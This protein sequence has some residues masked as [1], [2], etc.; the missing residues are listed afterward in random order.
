MKITSKY[1]QYIYF[2]FS[3][4]TL[5]RIKRKTKFL[6][7]RSLTK[8]KSDQ[9]FINILRLHVVPICYFKITHLILKI[10]NKNHL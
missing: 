2:N 5:L 10:K 8:L 4:G 6:K 3:K 7:M 1:P 9:R